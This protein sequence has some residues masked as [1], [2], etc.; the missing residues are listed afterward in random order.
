M[1]VYV[2]NMDRDRDRMQ[3]IGQQLERLQVPY[4]RFRAVDAKRLDKSELK[5]AVNGFRWWCAL[6][7]PIRIGEIGCAMSHYAIYRQMETPVCILEDDVILADDFSSVLE[8]V[9]EWLDCSRPQVVLLSNHSSKVNQNAGIFPAV[10][11]M[12]AEGYV[13]TPLAARRLVGVNWPMQRPCDHW[14]AWARRGLIELYHSFPTVCSQDQSRY[15]SGTVDKGCFKVSELSKVRWLLHK[16]LR[17]V[18]KTLDK[19]LP[20]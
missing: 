17:L 2:I 18:G 9:E 10:S 7:R 4:N 8:R 15:A 12:Y 1:N 5:G 3:A 20:L 14:G 16:G 13:I 11:D 6:G 19:I